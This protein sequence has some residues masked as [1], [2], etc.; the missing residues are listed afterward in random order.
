[1]STNSLILYK[2]PDL[3][4]KKPSHAVSLA[5]SAM[6]GTN[7]LASA[8]INYQLL[9]NIITQYKK[10]HILGSCTV[11]DIIN[12]GWVRW[13][14]NRPPDM[15]RVEEI[16]KKYIEEEN[17]ID[18]IFYFIYSDSNHTD[19][20]SASL[21]IYDGLHR[22]TAITEYIRQFEK[23]QNTRCPLRDTIVIIS[24]RI[25]P[26]KGEVVDAFTF[27]NQSVPVPYLYFAEHVK[28]DI[29]ELVVKK[30]QDKYKHHFK[31]TSRT[32]IPNINRDVFMDIVA[33]LYDHYNINEDKKKLG[34]ILNKINEYMGSVNFPLVPE[35]AL[36]KC[37]E[38]G[39]YM[40]L[41]KP[42][43]LFDFIQ[44]NEINI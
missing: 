38:T 5:A 29:V 32:H 27:I 4:R 15:V 22:M 31:S 3:M 40:F 6:A 42:T 11:D 16:I 24:I 39:C 1:M 35:K 25:N 7:E 37:K 10:N 8:K 20:K 23:Q 19:S 26:T 36:N 9:I 41:V 34:K 43:H 44:M 18:W 17:S 14:Y 30:W 2:Y 28:K 12:F 33:K 13:E 21:E